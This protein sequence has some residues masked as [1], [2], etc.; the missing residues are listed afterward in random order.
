MTV[1]C[2]S[3]REHAQECTTEQASYLLLTQ[4]NFPVDAAAEQWYR[5]FNEVR[6]AQR[7]CDDPGHGDTEEV[8][9]VFWGHTLREE[10]MK[11]V[12]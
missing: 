9:I 4:G 10:V 8:M 2:V 1:S 12:E 3:S 6:K 11:A 7:K 5:L